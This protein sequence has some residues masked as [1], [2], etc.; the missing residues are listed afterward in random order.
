MIYIIILFLTN[1]FIVINIKIVFSL[2]IINRSSLLLINARSSVVVRSKE[3][4]LCT[5][6]TSVFRV[7]L[8]NKIAGKGWVRA[9]KCNICYA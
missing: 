7:L 3:L 2:V 5:L 8:N 1:S 6:I 4:V 9:L